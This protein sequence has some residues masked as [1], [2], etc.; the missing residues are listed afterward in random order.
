MKNALSGIEEIQSDIADSITVD[1]VE[2][3]ENSAHKKD[4]FGFLNRKRSSTK[5]NFNKEDG[6]GPE[7]SSVSLGRKSVTA[8]EIEFGVLASREQL[9]RS[10]FYFR[11]SLP[12]EEFS[13]ERAAMFSDLYNP[14]LSETEKKQRRDALENLKDT[15]KTHFEKRK[16]PQKVK[17]YLVQWDDKKEKVTGLET[18]GEKVYQDILEECKAHAE[19]TWDQV[20]QNWREQ[21][22]TLLERFI[23]FHT[24][25]FCGRVELLNEIKDHLMS[26]EKDNWGMVL[27]G[28]SG[29]GK[30]AV[31]SMVKKAMDKEDCFVLAHSAGISPRA[32]NVLDLLQ[33]WN[34]LLSRHLGIKQEAQESLK[35][36]DRFVHDMTGQE[37]ETPKTEI[38][39]IQE[40]FRELLF[41][42]ASREQI[43]L[44]VDALDRFEPTER[45]QFMTW[46]P[47][48]MPGNV[49]MLCTAITDT[50]ENVVK[51]HTGLFTK[52]ID[53]FTETEAR[54]MLKMLC[55]QQRKILPQKVENMILEKKCSDGQPAT[56]SP[57]WLS[58][59]VNMLMALDQDDFEKMRYLK[60]RGDLQIETYMTDL[61]KGFDTLPGPLFL[62]LLSKAG[63]V[64]GQDFTR[65]VFNYL[66]CSRNGL[67]EKDLEKLLMAENNT[68]DPLQFANLRRW[69]KAHLVLQGEEM[70][71]N[72]AHSILPAALAQNAGENQLRKLHGNIANYLITLVNDPIKN[73]ETMNICCPKETIPE[74]PA[75]RFHM[76]ARVT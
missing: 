19:A 20:P 33:I 8:L 27:I 37:K 47:V 44:L 1:T 39:K 10:V 18:W 55:S 42:A 9:S 75:K 38:E 24:S 2:P 25:V 21:E 4:W 34:G 63:E 71:W 3:V 60:V 31:F 6:S 5:Q 7:T 66:A 53:C 11:E 65:T 17:S 26:K 49:R 58:L 64:F 16:L 29:S 67:R 23:E 41:T 59:A 74:N 22:L 43:V 72:L 70:Q 69:F 15:I 57:L 12:Y 35:T 28:E 52:D 50:Q 13:P 30:S 32:R 76:L 51:Y 61:V 14:A 36:D 46:L 54:E 56:T 62:S 45:A 73:T 68:W 40:R 48:V